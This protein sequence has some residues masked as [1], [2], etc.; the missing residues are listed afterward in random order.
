M[1]SEGLWIL[2]KFLLVGNNIAII[3]KEKKYSYTSL[4]QKIMEY[5]EWIRGRIP[6]GKVVALC[7]DYS[8]ESI[9]MF[10]S[11]AGNKNVIVPIV[12]LNQAETKRKISQSHAGYILSFGPSGPELH[13]SMEALSNPL[14]QELKSA[15]H[16]GLVLFSSGITGEPKSMLH[17]LHILIESYRKD[18][19]KDI[20]SIIFLTFDHIGGID[21]MLSLLSIGGTLV[22][23][24]E[25]DPAYICSLIE[26]FRVNTLSGSPTFLNL[27]VLSESYKKYDLSS[28]RIIGFGAEQMPEFL[29]RK[30]QTIFPGVQLQQ[31]FGT[32]ETNAIRVKNHPVENLFMKI[33]DPNIEYRFVDGELQLKSKTQILGYLNSSSERITDGWFRTGD[34]VELKDDGYFRIIG[35]KKEIINVGGE[36]VFPVEVEN[37]IMQVK[38]VTDCAVFGSPNLITGETVIAEATVALGTDPS[39]IKAEIRQLCSKLLDPYKRPSKLKIVDSIAMNDRFKKVRRQ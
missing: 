22:V 1:G 20:S 26:K 11:L 30:L 9:A 16:S 14:Y 3:H 33:E 8:F 10:F 29:Y 4:L 7:S 28:L 24:D 18:T 13:T 35:R 38:G 31:K 17:D 32:T 19:V 6:Q 37:V 23:P 36:K 15:C 27:M 39:I 5:D 2:E 12:S 21:T 25:K 34:I